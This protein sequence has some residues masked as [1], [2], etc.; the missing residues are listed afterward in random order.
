MTT[1]VRLLNID[2]SIIKTTLK[3]NYILFDSFGFTFV[4]PSLP[5][6][7]QTRI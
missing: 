1:C 6:Q 7:F 3:N 5:F 4:V 2:L